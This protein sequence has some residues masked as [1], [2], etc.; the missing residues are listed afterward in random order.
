MRQGRTWAT[1]DNAVEGHGLGSTQPCA[2]L[3][4]CRNRRL[5][6]SRLQVRQELMEQVHAQVSGLFHEPE[7]VL[8][9]N[10]AELG[11]KRF[12]QGAEESAIS[13]RQGFAVERQLGNRGRSG[14]R[15]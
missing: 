15:S 5:W 14:I 4:L 7:F 11:N 8:V 9:L 6:N 1:G 12:G 13:G 3:Q 2:V 10:E